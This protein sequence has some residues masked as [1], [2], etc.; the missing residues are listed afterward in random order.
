MEFMVLGERQTP[1]GIRISEI[2]ARTEIRVGHF[3]TLWPLYLLPRASTFLQRT[4]S[5]KTTNTGL[6]HQLKTHFTE[7]P[8]KLPYYGW[9]FIL[10]QPVTEAST[11]ACLGCLLHSS[12]GNNAH[13]QLCLPIHR[14]DMH[15]QWPNPAMFS[16]GL[17]LGC[18]FFCYLLLWFTVIM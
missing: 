3:T 8:T 15:V 7:K 1:R 14:L 16:Q 11:Q 9:L 2:W 12:L 4:H 5:R 18:L 10:V 13:W 17:L 6:S